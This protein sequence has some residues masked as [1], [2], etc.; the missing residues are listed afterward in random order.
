[1]MEPLVSIVIGV[2]NGER[3]IAEL[4]DSILAQT[5]SEWSC[6]CV[7]DGSSDASQ[8]ILESYAKKD[9]RFRIITQ[10]N[11]G[12]GA[13]RNAGLEASNARYIMFADQDDRLRPFAVASALS[14]IEGSD[15]DVVRFQSNKRIRRSNAVWERI[16]RLDAIR[17]VRFPPITGGEDNAFLW[18]LE[19]RGLKVREISDELYWN[20]D[21]DRSFSRVVSPKYIENVFAGYRCMRDVG[22]RYCIS[23]MRLFTMLF[24]HVFWFSV[25]IVVKHHSAENL[26]TLA[27]ELFK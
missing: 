5:V 15:F 3:F 23:S 9:S 26:K 8:E 11:G 20:R 22:R 10:K 14:A 1:M 24:P 12:V 27:K 25:S 17:D 6:I 4:L 7:N 18:E 2:Y 16:Y 21:N 13:A 19:C